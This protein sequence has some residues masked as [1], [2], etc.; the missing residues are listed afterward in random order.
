MTTNLEQIYGRYSQA[1]FTVRL[2]MFLQF[3]E[4]RREFLEIDQKE[5]RPEGGETARP[6]AK[7]CHRIDRWI[8]RKFSFLL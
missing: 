3:P 2:N 6:S 7:G 1:D 4:L 5:P 8:Q